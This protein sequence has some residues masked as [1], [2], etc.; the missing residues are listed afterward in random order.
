MVETD[1]TIVSSK[2]LWLLNS[3]QCNCNRYVCCWCKYLK[4]N[5]SLSQGLQTFLPEGHISYHTTVRGPDISRNVIFY[6]YVT[7]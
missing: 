1:I 4:L 7:F 5:L 6:G 2:K 3:H